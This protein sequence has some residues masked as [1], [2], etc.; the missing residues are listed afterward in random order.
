[1]IPALWGGWHCSVC[2]HRQ[3]ATQRVRA[4]HN[5]WTTHLFFGCGFFKTVCVSGLAGSEAV[6]LPRFFTSSWSLMLRLH[7]EC[8]RSQTSSLNS[9]RRRLRFV[10]KQVQALFLYLRVGLRNGFFLICTLELRRQAR[11]RED[12]ASRVGECSPVSNTLSPSWTENV[13][14]T[15]GRACC[16]RTFLVLMMVPC[17]SG[18]GARC[19]RLALLTLRSIYPSFTMLLRPEPSTIGLLR[20]FV[21]GVNNEPVCTWMK[22]AVTVSTH[23]QNLHLHL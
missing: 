12:S 13:S 21:C 20:D 11:R 5:S 22:E 23:W 8:V 9:S 19:G 10:R 15:T 1:M 18:M 7:Q 6:R 17:V 2:C 4:R 16:S 3:Q 14:S